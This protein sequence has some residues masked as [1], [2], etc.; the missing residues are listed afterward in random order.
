MN[1]ARRLDQLET[2][3][4]R[5]VPDW[6]QRFDPGR[7]GED[8]LAAYLALERRADLVGIDNLTADECEM[9]ADLAEK[10]KTGGRR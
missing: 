2:I 4:R 3:W 1:T 5:P 8:E 10:M 7:L 9:A 6:R